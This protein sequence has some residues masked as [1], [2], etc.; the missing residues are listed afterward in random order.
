[1]K[2]RLNL[3]QASMLR[4]RDL[5]PYIAIH[6]GRIDR[7]LDAARLEEIITR[8][9]GALGLTGF[10]LDVTRRRF[11]YTGGPA[12]VA[13]AVQ[14]GGRRP[15]DA[16]ARTIE[17]ELNEPFARDGRLN[18]FRFFCIDNGPWFHLGLA[19]DHVIAGGDSIVV[20]L[21]GIVSR[22]LGDK[23]EAPPSHCLDRYPATY[24]QLLLRH[25]A[26]ALT[27]VRFLRTIAASCRRTVRPRGLR[28]GSPA[29][30]FVYRRL[31]P[32]ELAALLRA[33]RAWGVTV[34]DL[35]LATL[36]RALEPFAG[37][38]APDERRQELAI[39]SIVNLRRDFGYDPNIT[40]GQFLSS[41]RIS[42]PLPPGIALQQLAREIHAETA[43]IR[44]RKLYLQTLL[45]IAA[46]GVLWRFL[47]REQRAGFYAKNYPTWGAITL[48][49][50]DA[51]WENAGGQMP[52]PEYL[53]AVSTGPLAPVVVA[54][55]IA[56]G[57][58]HAGFSYQDAAFTAADIDKIADGMVGCLTH[59]D[60]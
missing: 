53:R 16:L 26:P 15:S 9:L 37:K 21:E 22:Y 5:H 39:A 60:S 57:V 33:A 58:L 56:A 25:A 49:N 54:V 32:P 30:G 18:P 43:R 12:E 17:R 4:W 27:G 11:E 24:G 44:S 50:L 20:L 46:S 38:R 59:L 48:V 7:P 41:L 2:G 55:T 3:F 8:Q 10:M 23:P 47:S 42:H 34:N 31:D 35:L 36:L 51:L 40:F 1:M 14:A 52:A 28:G 13:L 6:V 19:Y 45:G 29:N